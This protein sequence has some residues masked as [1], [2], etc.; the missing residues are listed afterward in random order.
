M[1]TFDLYLYAGCAV[2]VLLVLIIGVVVA[3]KRKQKAEKYAESIPGVA[4]V[5]LRSQHPG[6]YDWADNSYILTIDGKKANSFLYK[7][8]IP[9]FYISPG[10]HTLKLKSNWGSGGGKKVS[11]HSTKPQEIHVKVKTEGHY[12]LGYQISSGKYMLE[13]YE[14]ERLFG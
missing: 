11:L 8:G 3:V 7:Y 1:N 14:N 6:D 4:I 10:E 5:L 12:S 9:A 13:E 2:F